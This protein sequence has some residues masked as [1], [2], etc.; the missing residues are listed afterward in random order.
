MLLLVQEVSL[1]NL[2]RATHI[3]EWA[4][5]ACYLSHASPLNFDRGKRPTQV[6]TF[7]VA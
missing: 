7:S 6:I 4:K 3:V 1:V 5:I 2:G